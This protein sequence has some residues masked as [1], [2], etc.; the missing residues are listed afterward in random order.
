[1]KTLTL[2][3]MFGAI[4]SIAVAQCASGSPG[5]SCT[6]PLNVQPQS[7]NSTQSAITLMDLALPLP[8]PTAGQ[9]TLSIANGML[10]ESD[11]GTGYHTLLGPQGAQ[12]PAGPTGPPGAAG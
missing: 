11:N 4:S 6:G 9:Y 3:L 5:T 7:G 1:M 10:V 8:S 12:G 2:I